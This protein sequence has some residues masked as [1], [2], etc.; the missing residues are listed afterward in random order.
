MFPKIARR[1]LIVILL[2]LSGWMIFA[3][4]Q[5]L[6]EEDPSAILQ[7]D[8]KLRAYVMTQDI[9]FLRNDLIELHK[10]HEDVVRKDSLRE[11]WA[12]VCWS[13]VFGAGLFLLG[14]EATQQKRT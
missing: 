6:R 3:H 11:M 13:V 7:A 9:E 2:V 14:V 12:L 1:V 4:R 8:G 10:K 5:G